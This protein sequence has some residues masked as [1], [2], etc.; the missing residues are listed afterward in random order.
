MAPTIPKTKA[1]FVCANDVND[2]FAIY[3]LIIPPFIA[4]MILFFLMSSL[5]KS[6]GH[7]SC[8]PGERQFPTQRPTNTSNLDLHRSEFVIND[9]LIKIWEKYARK[10]KGGAGDPKS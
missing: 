2:I 1:P 6:C 3:I 10:K 9:I 8:P 5:S 4:L 7:I